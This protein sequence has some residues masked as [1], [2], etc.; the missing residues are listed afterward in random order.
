M[1][2][3]F[4]FLVV[5]L[6]A[7]AGAC[8]DDDGGGPLPPDQAYSL[9][10][11]VQ[12][13]EV[14]QDTSVQLAIT[15]T[16]GASDVV[17]NPR[18]TYTS[19]DYSIANVSPAGLVTGLSGGSTN[20]NV[21]VSGATL[22]IPVT[23]RPHPATDVELTFLDGS[24][25]GTFFA[26]PGDANSS[27]LNA[28]VRV[29]NDTVFCNRCAGVTTRTHRVV[30]F[31]SL[32]TTKA[33]VRNAAN[34]FRPDTAGKVLPRDTTRAG[35]PMRI[36]LEVPGDQKADTV[37]VNLRL[38]PIDSLLVRTDSF[39]NPATGQKVAHTSSVIPINTELNLGVTFFSRVQDPPPPG[40]S[41]AP[42]PRWIAIPTTGS[43][44]RTSLPLVTWLSANQEFANVTQDGRVL[45]LRAF[46]QSA[47]QVLNCTNNP[48]IPSLVPGEGSLT[49]PNCTTP[50]THTPRPGVWCTTNSS[51][52]LN[53][54][55]EVWV[56]ASATDPVS[57]AA[58]TDRIAV[59]IR[60]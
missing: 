26:F 17:P 40:S 8:S 49:V 27:V 37:L 46:A 30:R 5:S 6:T 31:V 42:G 35:E 58:L 39:V 54:S 14:G 50:R 60:R 34:A 13:I 52:D 19:D 2:R 44:R 4:F 7:L 28:V 33:L 55:C 43:Q 20:I 53:A 21:A 59:V 23:V 51:S 3:R 32:D 24:T 22:S 10:S 57:G 47:G 11:A 41:T 48:T 56:R 16:R 9:Q 25:E 12:N 15:V 29:G 38:R 1:R 36:V 45:G 18:I